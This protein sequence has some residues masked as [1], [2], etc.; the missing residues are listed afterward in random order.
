MHTSQKIAADTP[1]PIK[2]VGFDQDL[3]LP[4]QSG[5]VDSVVVQNTR[6]IGQIAMR[7][8]DAQLRGEKVAGVT[9]VPPILLTRDT[10]HSSEING[11][12]DFA[13]HPWREQ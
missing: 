2:I 4:I 8:L 11:L 5:D 9:M 7:N 3:L 10:S 6:A 1:A 12:W 13:R